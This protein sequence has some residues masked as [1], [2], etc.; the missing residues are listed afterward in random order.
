MGLGGLISKGVGA[1]KGFV[2]DQG[3]MGGMLKKGASFGSTIGGPIGPALGSGG[4]LVSEIGK[5][6]ETALLRQ[7]SGK[8]PVQINRMNELRLYNKVRAQVFRDVGAK[9]PKEGGDIRDD[10]DAAVD[11]I[12]AV[13]WDHYETKFKAEL[14]SKS[15]KALFARPEEAYKIKKAPSAIGRAKPV[16][17]RV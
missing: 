3:G 1:A 10:A 2:R 11:Y 17:K 15:T 14:R 4:S 5:S 13:I 12:I 16:P 7:L 6:A 8:S 9:L